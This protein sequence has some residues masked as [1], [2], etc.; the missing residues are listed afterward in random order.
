MVPDGETAGVPFERVAS[1]QGVEQLDRLDDSHALV[2]ARASEDGP[3]NLE[4][5]ALP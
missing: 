5:V 4:A 1:M 3:L 2:M